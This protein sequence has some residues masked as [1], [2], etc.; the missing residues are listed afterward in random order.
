[1]IFYSIYAQLFT[2]VQVSSITWATGGSAEQ[3]LQVPGDR[4]LNQPK[5]H[6]SLKIV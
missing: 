2:Y 5:P 4:A 3:P 6:P 1:M